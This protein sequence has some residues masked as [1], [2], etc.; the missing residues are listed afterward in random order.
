MQ[1]FF[2]FAFH[3]IEHIL[4]IPDDSLLEIMTNGLCE[5]QDLLIGKQGWCSLVMSTL[6]LKSVQAVT[7][8]VVDGFENADVAVGGEGT[9]FFKALAGGEEPDDLGASAFNGGAGV[10]VVVLE[11]GWCVMKFEFSF[12]SAHALV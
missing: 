11:F 6:I 10:L 9:G 3:P 4:T 1:L 7:V 5:Q 8:V 2:A 12:E